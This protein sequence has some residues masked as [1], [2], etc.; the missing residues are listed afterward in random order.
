MKM[1]LEVDKQIKIIHQQSFYLF[2]AVEA[3]ICSKG[4]IPIDF[5]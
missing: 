5:Q 4:R 1:V 2:H 3:Q